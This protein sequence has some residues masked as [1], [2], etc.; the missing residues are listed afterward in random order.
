MKV[1]GARRPGKGGRGG[2]RRE[3][4]QLRRRH[5]TS[6]PPSDCLWPPGLQE[7]GGGTHWDKPVVQWWSRL[8]EEPS[9]SSGERLGSTRDG[10]PENRMLPFLCLLY[11]GM[12]SMATKK[13]KKSAF[14]KRSESSRR[15]GHPWLSSEA[16]L[17][18]GGAKGLGCR[19]LS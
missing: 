2:V 3:L 10:A 19:D 16:R 13:G 14:V 1:P 12:V 17:R 11:S 8:Q 6:N 7:R 4:S 9:A 5:Q 18:F 15:K